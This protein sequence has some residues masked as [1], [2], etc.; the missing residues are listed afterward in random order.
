MPNFFIF[1]R[2]RNNPEKDALNPLGWSE[3]CQTEI[4]PTCILSGPEIHQTRILLEPVYTRPVF[5]PLPELTGLVEGNTSKLL[6]NDEISMVLDD[7]CDEDVNSNANV[8]PWSGIQVQN[9][10]HKLSIWRKLIRGE[11]QIFQSTEAFWQ[12]LCKYAILN[13]FN[14]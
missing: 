1:D 12:V 11:E 7:E 10:Y 6:D 9:Y 3:T 8:W 4:H 14:Y 2:K 13:H 5:N